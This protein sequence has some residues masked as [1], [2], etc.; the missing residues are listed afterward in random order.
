MV[1]ALT[2]HSLAYGLARAAV[3]AADALDEKYAIAPGAEVGV[4]ADWLD[5]RLRT[6]AR[7]EGWSYV[8]GDTTTAGRAGAEATLSLSDRVAV[9]VDVAVEHAY[10]ETWVDAKLTWRSYFRKAWGER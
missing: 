7:V 1:Y 6:R 2:D 9:V 4:L 10:G 5:D 8:A 3:E